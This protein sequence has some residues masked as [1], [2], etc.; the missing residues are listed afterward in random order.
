MCRISRV[1]MEEY[2]S[3]FLLF[4]E[5]A[6]NFVHDPCGLFV[7][8]FVERQLPVSEMGQLATGTSEGEDDTLIIYLWQGW[9][10]KDWTNT[11]SL[12]A[13]TTVMQLHDAIKLRSLERCRA[14][15]LQDSAV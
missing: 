8:P 3:S 6:I 7:L 15:W 11:S 4:H 13:T 14:G 9:S 5:D 2:I 10:N 1:P 12:G